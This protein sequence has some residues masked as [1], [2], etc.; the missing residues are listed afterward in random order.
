MINR[1]KFIELSGI[2]STALLLPLDSCKKAL[3]PPPDPLKS[4][5]K[6]TAASISS[7]GLTISKCYTQKGC[8]LI[9]EVVNV[10]FDVTNT[11]AQSITLKE[12][13]V[14]LK[15]ISNLGA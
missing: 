13:H 14:F 7:G 4:N 1:R 15:D 9:N 10:S 2:A 12:L 8:Y 3:A 5:S 11:T 6:L